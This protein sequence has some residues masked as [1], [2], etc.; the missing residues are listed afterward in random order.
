MSVD[1]IPGRVALVGAGPGDPGLL[2]LRGLECLRQADVVICDYLVHPSLVSF[3]PSSA[4]VIHLDPSLRNSEW[5]TGKI[6]ATLAEFAQEGKRVVHLKGGD[7]AIF[8]RCTAVVEFLASHGIPFEIVPGITAASVAPSHAG[9]PLT[10]RDAASAV[11][12]VAG[13]EDLSKSTSLLDYEALAGFPGTLVIYMGAATAS[14][15]VAGLTRHGLSP[16]RPAALVQNCARP[17]Q[18]TV[19]CSLAE[20]PAHLEGPGA[21]ASPLLAIIGEVTHRGWEVSLDPRRP[22]LGISILVARA[23]HQVAP[24]REELRSLGATV[25]HQP[26]IEIRPLADYSAVDKAISNVDRYDWIVF[27]SVNGVDHFLRRLW[28]VGFDARKV[29]TCRIASIGPATSA[30]LSEAVIRPDM[31]AACHDSA[32]LGEE[33]RRVACGRRFLVVR[34]DRSQTVLP[35]I[36]RRHGGTVEELEVYATRN[37][38]T[39]N[40]SVLWALRNGHIQWTLVSSAEIAQ[41]LATLFS[42][43]LKKSRLV[44]ISPQ[45]TAVL[46]D[47][48]YD[49]AIES[50]V[51]TLSGMIQALSQRLEGGTV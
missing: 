21:L 36:L 15:W 4:Q 31:E 38:A 34:G 1:N 11:A 46:R 10:D 3:A 29:G 30:R 18:R 2:T 41:S 35:G 44:S 47:L 43:D 8:G 27:L 49:V 51:R 50:R 20:I 13:R 26:A 28:S 6:Q 45:T 17:E 7:P 33:L 42:D 40:E 37:V 24:V 5:S 25:F 9:I 48:G 32:S 19:R 39:P 23:I 12:L 16:D 22:L 14:D